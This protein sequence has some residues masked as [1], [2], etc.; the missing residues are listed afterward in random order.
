MNVVFEERYVQRH[1]QAFAFYPSERAS[2]WAT[3]NSV[4]VVDVVDERVRMGDMTAANVVD[5]DAASVWVIRWHRIGS[6]GNEPG[7]ARLKARA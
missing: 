3:R 5:A 6:D 4:D 2:N 7:S 1:P